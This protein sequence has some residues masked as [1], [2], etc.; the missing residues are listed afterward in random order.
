MRLRNWRIETLVATFVVNFV[1]VRQFLDFDK[2]NDKGC[3]EE[4]KNRL[5]QPALTN[6]C[7]YVFRS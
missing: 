7:P 1:G 6:L 3:D 5:L 4:A 2:V